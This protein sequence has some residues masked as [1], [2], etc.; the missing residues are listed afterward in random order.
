MTG[1]SAGSRFRP[2]GLPHE[3]IIKAESYRGLRGGE[4]PLRFV[5]VLIH[6][7]Q[8]E[9]AQERRTEAEASADYKAKS[10]DCQS[11]E[12]TVQ[13]PILPFHG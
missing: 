8:S 12:L 2:V 4:G 13:L 9:S 5:C 6:L 1:W 10:L 3:D 7:P 11:D